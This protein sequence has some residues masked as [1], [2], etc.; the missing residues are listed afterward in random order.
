MLS[1]YSDS[2][3]RVIFMI[4]YLVFVTH[5]RLGEPEGQHCIPRVGH[6][7]GTYYSMTPYGMDA[8]I[9]GLVEPAFVIQ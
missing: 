6:I 5:I 1:W 8:W 7:L 9:D 3:G 4:V 2:N